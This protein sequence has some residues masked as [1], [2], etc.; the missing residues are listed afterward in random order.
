MGLMYLDLEMLGA[1]RRE[2]A[3]FD[4]VLCAGRQVLV[5]HDSELKRLRVMAPPA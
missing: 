3:R 4:R 1:A 5:L 2:G